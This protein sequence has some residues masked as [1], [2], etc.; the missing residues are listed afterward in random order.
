[1][2]FKSNTLIAIISCLSLE[3]MALSALGEQLAAQPTQLSACLPSDLPSS[4]LT[5]SLMC[6]T[7]QAE[8]T[9]Q[10]VWHAW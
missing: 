7:L 2:P 6:P 9:E 1:M 3:L 4:A 5:R 10:A 8:H